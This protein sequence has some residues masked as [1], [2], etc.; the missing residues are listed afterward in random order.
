MGHTLSHIDHIAIVVTSI[1]EVRAFYEDALGLKIANFET[2]SKRGI[3]TAFIPIGQTM[4]ELIEPLHEQS[5]VSK[6]LEK[7]G[8]GLHHIAF[9]TANIKKTEAHLRTCQIRLTYENAQP[10]A[11]D[12]LVNFI[13][14]Q[15]SGGVL[16]EIVE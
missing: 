1:N 5:E 13:H 10:G 8:P 4:I 9:K 14:P 15:S 11:H 16:L 12:S 2:I 6:F 3:R 7:K